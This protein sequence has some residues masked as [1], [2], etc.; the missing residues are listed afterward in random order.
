MKP[1]HLLLLC[2]INFTISFSQECVLYYPAT[3]GAELEYKNY[4][5]KDKLT[6]VSRQTVKDIRT[7]PN[8][9][10]A[11]VAVKSEDE[12]GK[13]LY[14][15]VITVTCKD[16]VYYINMEDIMDKAALNNAQMEIKSEQ[17]EIPS[18]LS[19]GMKLK[20]SK[21]S[22]SMNAGGFSMN[23]NTL[24]TDRTVAALENTTTPAGT[25]ECYKITYNVVTDAPVKTSTKC[26]QWY[27]KNIGLV[28]SET[29]AA[30]NSKASSS[31]LTAIKK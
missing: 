17:I 18:K 8:G 10:E 20:N 2:M 27:S 7:L 25:F 9:M 21:V 4:D 6:G 31:V 14:E 12:K 16:G 22:M 26:A 24:I 11:D 1:L 30:D 3:K 5:K 19:V 23:F 29:Y 13:V 28:K 15:D